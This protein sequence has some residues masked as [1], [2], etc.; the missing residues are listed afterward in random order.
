MSKANNLTQFCGVGIV[1]IITQTG[2][3]VTGR[4]VEDACNDFGQDNGQDQPI[5]VIQKFITVKLTAPFEILPNN[6]GLAIVQTYYQT[7]DLMKISVSK[8]ITVGPSHV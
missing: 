8:I 2:G 5:P 3:V 1:T 7:G 6:G 4:I